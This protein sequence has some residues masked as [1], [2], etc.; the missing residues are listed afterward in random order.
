MRGIIAQP[1]DKNWPLSMEIG[2]EELDANGVLLKSGMKLWN[3]NVK[4][5]TLYTNDH[6]DYE[7]YGFYFGEPF[8]AVLR[9]EYKVDRIAQDK[10]Y[11][12]NSVHI[13]MHKNNPE[14]NKPVQNEPN[15]FQQSPN[16]EPQ[17]RLLYWKEVEALKTQS[18]THYWG[19]F[20][21]G[22]VEGAT[23]GLIQSQRHVS[24]EASSAINTGYQPK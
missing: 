20:W 7:K 17:F 18:T 13:E 5:F 23:L 9:K 22:L 1:L 16:T 8:E 14:S 12:C 21:R 2:S 11:L 19:S 15:N 10:Y 24:Q 3:D 4:G 6:A